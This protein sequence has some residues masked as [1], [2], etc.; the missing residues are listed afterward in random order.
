MKEIYKDGMNDKKSLQ[1]KL[2]HYEI[3]RKKK[4]QLVRQQ[5]MNIIQDPP[6]LRYFNTNRYERTIYKEIENKLEK[7][8][9]MDEVKE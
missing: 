3:R 6:Q 1:I 8:K 5:R 2:E 9:I 4:L 7:K